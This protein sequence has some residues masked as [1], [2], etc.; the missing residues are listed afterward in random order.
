MYY[1]KQAVREIEQRTQVLINALW[2]SKDPC[3][4]FCFRR[5]FY[6]VKPNVE[7]FLINSALMIGQQK[8]PED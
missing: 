5:A 4:R 2:N 8:D 3:A 6:G 7:E 1:R